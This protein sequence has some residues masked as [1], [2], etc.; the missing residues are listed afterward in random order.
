MTIVVNFFPMKVAK[1]DEDDVSEGIDINKTNGLRECLICHQWYFLK[2][3]FRFQPKLCNACLGLMWKNMSFND[4]AVVFVKENGCRIH[5]WY[6]SKD[7][8]INLLRNAYLTGKT[9]NIRK[10]TFVITQMCN[11]IL[12]FSDKKIEKHE[13][14]HYKNLMFLEDGNIDNTLIIKQEFFL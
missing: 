11:K 6:M 5:F 12:T 3:N 9:W 13:F 1:Y 7:E 4:V 2:I 10:Q 14:H 8:T